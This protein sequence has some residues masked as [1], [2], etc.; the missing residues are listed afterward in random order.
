VE[1]DALRAHTFE[2]ESLVTDNQEREFLM[3]TQ[4]VKPPPITVE[5]YEAF[6]GY[7][8]LRDELINGEII[9]SP[10]PKPLHQQI[11]ENIHRLLNEVLSDQ[12]VAK[13]NSS[14]KLREA[15]SMPAP[16]VFV[17]RRADWKRACESDR[18]LEMPP[19]LAVEVISPAN[20]KSR[21]A[22]KIDLY[23]ST[24]VSAV[25]VCYPKKRL[26]RTY[27]AGQIT[28]LSE[29]E[30]VVL[31]EPLLGEIKVQNMFLLDYWPVSE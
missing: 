3:A 23:L 11:S 18:Y 8:G 21:V 15:N 7:P 4:I 22:Q 20:R 17:V 31:S 14:I 2:Q 30:T 27:H 25:W 13:Q 26:L 19:I 1:C 24:G 29:T 6:E 12:F 16:D 28:E 10:Q 5:Q 9:L